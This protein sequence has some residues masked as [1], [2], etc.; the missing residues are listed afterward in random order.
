[1]L[2]IYWTC[3]DMSEFLLEMLAH[4]TY[5]HRT[6]ST[7]CRN[8][9]KAVVWKEVKLKCFETVS[10]KSPPV[11]PVLVWPVAMLSTKHETS[12]VVNKSMYNGE[13]L[14]KPIVVYQYN[15]SMNLVDHNDYMLH[16]LY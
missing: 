4:D 9:P 2:E 6:V 14:M 5:G 15:I 11:V 7:N 1:M 10:L 3:I 8:L 12:E 16:M 13:F